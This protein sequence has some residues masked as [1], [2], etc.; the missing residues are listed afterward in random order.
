MN[1]IEDDYGQEYCVSVWCAP[2]PLAT[3]DG[4]AVVPST[5]EVCEW[6]ASA[7]RGIPPYTYTWTGVASGSGSELNS[8]VSGEGFLYVEVEDAIGHT[9]TASLYITIDSEAE[10]PECSE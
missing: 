4:P 1:E 9:D 3:I 2:D 6:Q 10:P 7:T 8:S 5:S